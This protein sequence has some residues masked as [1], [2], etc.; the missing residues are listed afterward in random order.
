CG[1][2]APD[3]NHRFERSFAAP[4]RPIMAVA[5]GPWGPRPVC[6]K[7]HQH[8]PALIVN[9]G[10]FMATV[11][12]ATPTREDFAKLLEESFSHGSPQEGAVVQGTLFVI[13]MDLA[14]LALAPNNE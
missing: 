3:V 7:C 5:E 1:W 11:S 6:S 14:V 4:G 2:A 13:E 12:S 8:R 9:S 10:V